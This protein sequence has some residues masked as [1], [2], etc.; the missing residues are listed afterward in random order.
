MSVIDTSPRWV[1]KDYFRRHSVLRRLLGLKS[2]V[3]TGLHAG[4]GRNADGNHLLKTRLRSRHD[5]HE[6]RTPARLCVR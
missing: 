4:V 1:F 6:M 3:E 5:A 2:A